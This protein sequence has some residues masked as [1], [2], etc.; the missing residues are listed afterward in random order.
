[1]RHWH[2][3]PRCRGRWYTLC[4]PAGPGSR[5]HRRRQSRPRSRR[6]QHPLR[7]SDVF[8]PPRSTLPQRMRAP[9]RSGRTGSA[10]SLTFLQRGQRGRGQK[11][12]SKQSRSALSVP[13]L[14]REVSPSSS[15]VP[16][17]TDGAA[18]SCDN[19]SVI[20]ERRADFWWVSTTGA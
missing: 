5:L 19:V 6:T 4:R 10:S 18:A 2:I 16:E 14:Q 20:R 17:E 8:F 12:S 15:R 7:S 1:M 3:P 11:R 9:L 13:F